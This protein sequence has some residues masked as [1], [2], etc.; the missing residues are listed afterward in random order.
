MNPSRPLISNYH[1]SK[2]LLMDIPE[3]RSESF[4]NRASI[5][6][7]LN[8]S[9]KYL[10]LSKSSLSIP[11]GLPRLDFVGT[12][13]FADA[14]YPASRG[15]IFRLCAARCWGDWGGVWVCWLACCTWGD[16]ERTGLAS[17]VGSAL[18]LFRCGLCEADLVP[19]LS[20][21][22]G[23][24]EPNGLPVGAACF[25]CCGVLAPDVLGVSK[26]L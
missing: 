5:P 12:A 14:K 10:L 6:L 15:L 25:G 4:F 21:V 16:G 20:F 18:F 7:V 1:E 26:G 17:T 3:R 22:L 9:W 23:A 13:L 19:E 24:A 8:M 11:N 2:G